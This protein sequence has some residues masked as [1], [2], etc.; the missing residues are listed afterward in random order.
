[1]TYKCFISNHQQALMVI[2]C[3]TMSFTGVVEPH[4]RDGGKNHHHNN[5][6]H[7]H[8]HQ[9]HNHH[10]NSSRNS[11]YMHHNSFTSSAPTPFDFSGVNNFETMNNTNVT[12]QQS[13]TAILPCIVDSNSPATVTWIRRS[14][15]QLLT[16]GL[17]TYS[18]DERFHVEHTRHRGVWDLRIKSVRKDDEGVYECNLSLYPPE[19][20]FITLSVVEAIAEI[21]GA[22]DD[23]HIDEGSTLRLECKIM[24]VTENPS[25]VFW[26]HE[27]RMVNF[28][29][30]DGYS[31]LTFPK[32]SL[33]H[34]TYDDD[35]NTEKILSSNLDSNNLI[36]GH[37]FSGSSS[38]YSSNEGILSSA[39][40]VLLVHEV[41]FKHQGNYTCA[42]SNT[43][44]TSI[45]VHVLKGDQHKPAAMK[46]SNQS[47]IADPK[48]SA[49]SLM[50]N[51][52]LLYSICS[53]WLVTVY[54]NVKIRVTT[55]N[56]R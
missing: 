13:G 20:I 25:Y 19:S 15:Y 21:S 7:H 35:V 4:Q 16:V 39:S 11:E 23:V 30:Q 8:N 38:S 55:S 24:Q 49:H 46:H 52:L 54:C 37:T 28:N 3:F 44:P 6:H 1:M 5:H 14:D 41:Q 33:Y 27:D 48:S 50:H 51:L 26:F 43:R 9:Y 12:A 42:P 18:S 22:P 56:G 31:V 2:M 29:F 40:S 53:L 45:N 32:G 47:T 17:A 34:Y 10:N 36:D